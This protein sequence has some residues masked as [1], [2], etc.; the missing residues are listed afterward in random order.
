MVSMIWVLTLMAPVLY[1]DQGLVIIFY[2][3]G[4]RVSIF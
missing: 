1:M 4:L 2:K 3:L